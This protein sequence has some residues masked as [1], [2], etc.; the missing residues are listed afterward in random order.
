MRWSSHIQ[1]EFHVLRLTLS[2]Y[3][4]SPF[5]LQESHLLRYAFPCISSMKNIRYREFGFLRFRSS[6][7]TES[8]ICFLFLIL[9]RYFNSDGVACHT[10]YHVFNMVSC[11]I[12][13]S[14]DHCLLPTP[15]GVSPVVASFIAF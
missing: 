11:L 9:L 3:F 10:T 13:K 1:T 7:L 4:N 6:L 14:T 15:R 5:R 8:L 2:H 12:R